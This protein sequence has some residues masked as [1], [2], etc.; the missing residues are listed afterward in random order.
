MT[1]LREEE[2]EID[3]GTAFVWLMSLHYWAEHLLLSSNGEGAL[4]NYRLQDSENHR[5][6]SPL[7]LPHTGGRAGN[8][9]LS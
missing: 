3:F 5:E 4:C 8:N 2:K 9:M 7:T 6:P 1:M